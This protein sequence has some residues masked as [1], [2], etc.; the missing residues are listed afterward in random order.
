MPPFRAR[1]PVSLRTVEQQEPALGHMPDHVADLIHV[2]L[3]EH[4]GTRATDTRDNVPDRIP[5]HLRTARPP[6]AHEQLGELAL[7]P[8][9]GGHGTELGKQ[10]REIHARTLRRRTGPRCRYPER[11]SSSSLRFSGVSGSRWKSCTV[12]V[13]VSSNGSPWM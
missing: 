12:S 7:S 13:K 2:R 1:P 6:A 5:A 11:L 8:G 10:R 3:Q 4:P 9:R